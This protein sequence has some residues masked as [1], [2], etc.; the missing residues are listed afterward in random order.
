VRQKILQTYLP[1]LNLEICH[2]V[3]HPVRVERVERNKERSS[4]FC[5]LPIFDVLISYISFHI[6]CDI[7]CLEFSGRYLV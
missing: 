2:P 7:L 3:S 5:P 4:M 1:K 6:S